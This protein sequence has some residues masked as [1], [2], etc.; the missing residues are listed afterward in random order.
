MF[1]DGREGDQQKDTCKQ[2]I[3]SV[4]TFVPGAKKWDEGKDQMEEKSEININDNM[5]T[6]NRFFLLLALI[7]LIAPLSWVGELASLMTTAAVDRLDGA[8]D[9]GDKRKAVV[10]EPGRSWQGTG[11][12]Q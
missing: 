4:I 10:Q 9:H 11:A 6:T 8:R 1:I 3:N 5:V 7:F 12:R 2:E